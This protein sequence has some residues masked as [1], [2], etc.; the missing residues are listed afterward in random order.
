MTDEGYRSLNSLPEKMDEIISSVQ[1]D[2]SIADALINN[3]NFFD[4]FNS[5]LSDLNKIITKQ[6]ESSKEYSQISVF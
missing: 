4:H 6:E 3:K 2:S 1:N 5:V